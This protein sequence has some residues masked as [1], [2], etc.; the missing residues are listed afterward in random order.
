[1]T[2]TTYLGV[3]VISAIVGLP[4]AFFTIVLPAQMR[5]GGASLTEIGLVYIVWLPSALKWLWAPFIERLAVSFRTRTRAIWLLSFFLAICFLLVAP[6]TERMATGYLVTLAALCAAVTLSLQLLYAGWAMQ[7]LGE[8]QRGRANGTAA[9]GM[10]LGG[11]VGAAALP[12]I[13]ASLGWW[14]TVLATSAG[15]A[16]AGLSGGLLKDTAGQSGPAA[17]PAFAKGLSVLWNAPLVLCLLLTAAAS[18]ADVTLPARLVDAGISPERVGLIMGSIA[19]TLMVPA[20]FLSG[21][22]VSKFDIG[23]C[24]LTCGILKCMVL[25]ALG[26]APVQSEGQVVALSVADF[27]L[28]GAFTVLIWQF[29]M[30]HS[31]RSAPVASYAV[32]TSLDALIRFCSATG[33]GFFA[34]QA[35]Y[36][37][38]FFSAG[39]ITLMSGLAIAFFTA[40]KKPERCSD[41]SGMIRLHEGCGTF[42]ENRG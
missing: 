7:A 1:M 26:F 21:W 39:L 37:P 11:I 22:L 16:C 5:D 38:L 33:A 8:E 18:G 17:A 42:P 29:Y 31:Q 12:F 13:A 6:L 24:V 32:L 19:M 14:I 3:L 36:R 27:V 40:R 35:G 20:S 4:A 10:L 41:S 25:F 34:E 15:L 2:R 9:G 30:K 28:A 23:L